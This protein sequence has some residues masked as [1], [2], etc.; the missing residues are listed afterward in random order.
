MAK[1]NAIVFTLAVGVVIGTAV[2]PGVPEVAI[3]AAVVCGAAAMYGRLS[4][5]PRHTPNQ[6]LQQTGGA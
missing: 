3:V 1:F 6:A 4:S 5:R 2:R